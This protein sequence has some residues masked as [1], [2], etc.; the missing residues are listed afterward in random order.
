MSDNAGHT[1]AAE[2]S[3]CRFQYA[4]RRVVLGGWLLL[5]RNDDPFLPAVVAVAAIDEPDYCGQKRSATVT[6]LFDAYKVGRTRAE[7]GNVSWR[8]DL[9]QLAK[10]VDLLSPDRDDPEAFYLKKNLVACELR[11][12]AKWRP[13]S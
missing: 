13:H 11:R 2:V 1:N 10:L 9:L 3:G 8:D 7:I 4:V 5:A 6:R 12:L